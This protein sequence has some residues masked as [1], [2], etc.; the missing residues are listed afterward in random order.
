MGS[1]TRQ[2]APACRPQMPGRP[3]LSPKSS[4]FFRSITRIA[5]TGRMA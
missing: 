2:V 1:A 4:G 3:G 5:R